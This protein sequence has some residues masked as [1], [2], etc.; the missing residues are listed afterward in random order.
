MLNDVVSPRAFGAANFLS[1]NGIRSASFPRAR[2]RPTVWKDA[3]RCIANLRVTSAAHR[4]QS[5]WILVRPA[6]R[7]TGPIC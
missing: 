2:G 7:F 1:D 4:D 5:A 6:R 3:E